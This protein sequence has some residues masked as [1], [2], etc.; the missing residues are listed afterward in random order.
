M[1]R[2]RPSASSSSMKMMAGALVARLLEQ[3]AHARGA[4]ADEHLHEFRAGDREERHLRLARRPPWPAASCRCRGARPAGRL[5]ASGRRAGRSSPGF[6]RKSTISRSSS[7]ASSTPATSSKRHAGVGLDV[8]LG[9][10]LAD[11]HQAAAQPW[12]TRRARNIQTPK[13][14]STGTIQES[15]S[16]TNVLSTS[17][18]VGHV[19]FLQFAGELGI[20]PRGHE[21]GLAVRQRLS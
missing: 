14:S 17:P 13:N 4:D 5:S 11:R 21:L 15:R 12:L 3:I 9:L 8:D 18:R 16:C 10:A 19:V 20:D 6:F 7:L 1:P 2:A